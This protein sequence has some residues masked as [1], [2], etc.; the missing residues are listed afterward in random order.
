MLLVS[1]AL[2]AYG[3]E[4]SYQWTR[5]AETALAGSSTIKLINGSKFNFKD[6]DK[7]AIAPSYDGRT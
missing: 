4:N 1:G 7:L 3:I 6:G 2:K 5:L